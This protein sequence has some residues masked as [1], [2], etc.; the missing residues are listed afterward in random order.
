[1]RRVNLISGCRTFLLVVVFT[2]TARADEVFSF[3]LTN[4]QVVPPSTCD[5]PAVG[6]A[7]LKTD[8]TQVAFAVFH[9]LPDANSNGATV[10]V[11]YVGT[12]GAF[13]YT[14]DYVNTNTFGATFP[15]DSNG[16]ADLRAGRLYV[17][18]ASATCPG[19]AVRG[20]IAVNTS[21]QPGDVIVSEIMYNPKSQEGT[22]PIDYTSAPEWIELYNASPTD[23]NIGGWF[24]QDEDVSD[25]APCELMYSGTIP[26][27][28]L[29]SR[30]VV[31][32]IPDGSELN[33]PTVADFKEAWDL[34][35]DANVLQLNTNGTAGGAIVGRNLSNS[36]RNDNNPIND[37]DQFDPFDW[38]PCDS[39]G[40]AREDAQGNPLYDNEV[41]TLNDG[42][43]IIDVVN[44]DD[45]F[46]LGFHPTWPES[47]SYSSITIVPADY[48]DDTDF[49]TYTAAGNDEGTSWIAHEDG[50]IAGGFQQRRAAGVYGGYDVGSPGYLYGVTAGNRSPVSLAQS[51]LLDKGETRTIVM[52]GTD[53]TR[54][55]FGLLLFFIK[56]L[57]KHGQL[58]DVASNKLITPAMLGTD[59]YLMP[60]IP[61]DQVRYVNDGTCGVDSFTFYNH[62]GLLASDTATVNLFVQ[63]GEVAITEIMYNPDSE[64][65]YPAKPEWIE[66]YNTTDEPIDLAGWYLADESTRSGDFPSYILGAKSAVVAIPPA[67]DPADFVSAWSGPSFDP[68]YVPSFV[69]VTTNG[70]TLVGGITGSNLANSGENLQLIRP[71]EPGDDVVK[72]VDAV[73]YVNGFQDPA[74]PKVSPDGPSIYLPSSALLNAIGNDNPAAWDVSTVGL[75]GAYAVKPNASYDH[76]AGTPYTS[77]DVGSPGRLPGIIQG[78]CAY[79]G[80]TADGN[81][82]TLVNLPDFEHFALC[83]GGP[84]GALPLNCDCFDA[85][86][87]GDVDLYDFGAMQRVFAGAAPV[88]P[89]V[90]L[91]EV[92]DG[93]LTGG[94]PKWLEISNCGTEAV[95]LSNYRIALFANGSVTENFLSMGYGDMSGFLAPGDSYVVANDNSGPGA[96]F[97]SVYG[98][99]A[100]LYF[101]SANSNGNDVYH[102]LR[103][104]GTGEVLVDAHGQIGVD[105]EGTAW[106]YQDSYAYSLPGRAPNGG[107]FQASN[108]Y[109]AGADA[110]DGVGEAGIAAVTTPGQ[111]VCGP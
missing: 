75:N 19:G 20:Q 32:I 91:S 41:L 64:E 111:H 5:A 49:S 31:V 13:M 17:Q 109:H 45:D 15:I 65:A 52:E 69:H 1:M 51:Q 14:L 43:Q 104:A 100:D 94:K 33:R 39:Q 23:I 37:F 71:Q 55:F 42:T 97:L 110:L 85:D 36:P 58:W 66:L 25:G 16:V 50:D 67:V 82:D 89:P 56:T 68:T 10:Q 99:E 74:W 8:E 53:Q 40:F 28:V 84:D 24:F 79:G 106:W 108:W 11:G 35:D 47:T 76:A 2:A 88:E 6:T 80:L 98:Y 103:S 102:L 70:Q 63:C 9:D 62:D 87:D 44:Y 4:D 83:A 61:F 54:P 107:D 12:N 93:T 21:P 7:T 96:E 60:R 72:V 86:A 77:D 81:R 22:P 90:I 95:D 92:V 27:F 26:D 48:P 29:R 105:G 73:F 34:A 30:T 3:V 57:P 38:Q 18:V 78:G 59:G 46:D 101:G